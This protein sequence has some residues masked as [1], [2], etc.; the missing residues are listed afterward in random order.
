[1]TAEEELAALKTQNADLQAKLSATP[2]VPKELLTE[3]ETLKKDNEART[4]REKESNIK[5]AK[6]TAASAYPNIKGFEDMVS[7]GTEEEISANAKALSEKMAARDQAQKTS[8]IPGDPAGAWG[9]IPRSANNGLA[10]P[11]ERQD[12]YA[13]VRAMETRGPKAMMDKIVKLTGMHM[14]DLFHKQNKSDRARL[15]LQ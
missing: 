3:L 6:M 7:G 5:L 15:G 9:S 4:I 12:E 13:A 11:K 10:L 1:M 14:A 2:A 8:G